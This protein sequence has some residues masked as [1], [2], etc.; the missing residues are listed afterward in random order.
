MNGYSKIDLK[1]MVVNNDVEALDEFLDTC[2]IYKEGVDFFSD[3]KRLMLSTL[4]TYASASAKND[5]L[6]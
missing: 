1:M 6:G 4:F 2:R 5:E 3:E